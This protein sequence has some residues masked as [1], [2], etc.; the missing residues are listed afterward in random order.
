MQNNP[1][2]WIE[3]GAKENHDTLADLSDKERKAC[4]DF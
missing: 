3:E 2:W 1:T 4:L